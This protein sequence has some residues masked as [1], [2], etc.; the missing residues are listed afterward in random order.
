MA[1]DID[2]IMAVAS[3]HLLELGVFDRVNQHEPKA[4]PG[5]GITAAIWV[6]AVEPVRTSGLQQTSAKLTFNVRLF[7]SMLAEPQDS[8]DPQLVKALDALMTVYS[9]DFD[10]GGLARNVDLL[11]AYGVGL[12]A[13]AGYITQDNRVYRVYTVTL[14]LIF[15][16][17]WA[18]VA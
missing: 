15:N 1:L 3:S 14:P 8:I 12:G 13:V 9:G 11:G 7:T 4:A 5:N 2:A 17:V 10:L 16:D 18:Q 6:Q